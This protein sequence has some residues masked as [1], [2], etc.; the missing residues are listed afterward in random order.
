LTPLTPATDD[1]SVRT[2]IEEAERQLEGRGHRL[3]EPRRAVLD[4]IVA[5]GSPFTVEELC[6]AAPEVGRATV[7]R[8]VKLLQ[9]TDVICRLAL[10]DGGVRYQLS[11]GGHH[12]H[13]ICNSCGAVEEFGDSELDTLIDRNAREHGFEVSSH[14]L[15][16]YGKCTSCAAN[17]ER[18][19]RAS[20]LRV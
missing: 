19:G 11:H 9:E 5:T 17:A 8:T 10:D 2:P 16:L 18:D 3:T 20:A 1:L 15:E 14:S 12:H 4:A 6:N 13:L 7:F